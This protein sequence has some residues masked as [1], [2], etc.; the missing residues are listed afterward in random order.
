MTNISV[1]YG[2]MEQSAAVL[3]AGRDDITEKLRAMQ[4][5]IRG[6]ASSGFVTE[7]ASQ[8][9]EATFAEYTTHATGVIDGLAELQGFILQAAAAHRELDQLLSSRLG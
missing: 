6:L 5:H 1:S 4:E 3:G 2:E 7:T 8:R 9:F